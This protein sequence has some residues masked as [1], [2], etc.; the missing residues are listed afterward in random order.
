MFI[1]I[2]LQISRFEQLY[3]VELYGV[4]SVSDSTTG[5]VYSSLHFC[6][7]SLI[8]ECLY[9]PPLHPLKILTSTKLTSTKKCFLLCLIQKS[10]VWDWSLLVVE[11]IQAKW[12]QHPDLRV[13]LDLREDVRLSGPG[14][15]PCWLCLQLQRRLHMS[16][17][18]W[19]LSVSTGHIVMLVFKVQKANKAWWSEGA[20]MSTSQGWN[21]LWGLLAALVK[22]SPR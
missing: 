9:L 21:C 19:F 16:P 10:V 2:I 6:Q 5:R 17:S 13:W 1:W 20:T 12:Q 18:H 3:L 14:R 8:D 15:P 22:I 7:V 4:V 11:F